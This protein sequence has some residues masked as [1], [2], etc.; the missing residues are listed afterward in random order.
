[1]FRLQRRVFGR[2]LQDVGVEV[3]LE[4]QVRGKHAQQVRREVRPGTQGGQRH[5][6]GCAAEQ[7]Q[8]KHPIL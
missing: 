6:S 1:M 5:L 2:P 4:V 8:R 7:E 3:L